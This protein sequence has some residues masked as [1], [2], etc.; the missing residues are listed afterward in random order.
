MS[1]QISDI[2]D[3][4]SCENSEHLVA[5]YSRVWQRSNSVFVVVVVGGGGGGVFLN[6]YFIVPYGKSGSPDPDK[7]A[8]PVTVDARAALPIPVSV[9]GISV[10][11]RTAVDACDCTRGLYGHRTERLHTGAVRTPHWETA[12][13]G[14]TDTALRESA[15]EVDSGEKSLAAPGTRTRVSLTPGFSVGRFTHWAVRAAQYLK[16]SSNCMLNC[17]ILETVCW[18]KPRL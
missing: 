10:D 12:H 1:C 6:F 16:L 18:T 11:V 2:V 13:G 5:V 9:C 8:S 3:Y 4:H 15:L 7:I 17:T 14:R